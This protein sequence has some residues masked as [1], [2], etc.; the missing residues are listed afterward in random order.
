[1][2]EVFMFSDAEASYRFATAA[3]ELKRLLV[4][5]RRE[6]VIK[7]QPLLGRHE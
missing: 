5:G 6:G 3:N 4:R 1:M 7:S 2:N